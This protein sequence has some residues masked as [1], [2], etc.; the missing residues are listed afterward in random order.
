M[1]PPPLQARLG[2]YS[3]VYLYPTQEVLPPF[4][5]GWGSRTEEGR[6]EM[7]AR[8]VGVGGGRG[9]PGRNVMILGEDLIRKRFVYQR[10]KHWFSM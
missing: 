10:K 6:K 1:P 3:V 9:I 2:V 8:K 7:V 4:H 5:T